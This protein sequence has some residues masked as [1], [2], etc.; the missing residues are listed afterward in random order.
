MVVCPLLVTVDLFTLI[1]SLLYRICCKEASQWKR[2]W[3]EAFLGFLAIG[4]AKIAIP[5]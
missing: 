5:S 1:I 3:R 2:A 4:C